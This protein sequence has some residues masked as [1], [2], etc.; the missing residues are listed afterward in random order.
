MSNAAQEPRRWT[1][2]RHGATQRNVTLDRDPLMAVHEVIEVVDA[3]AYDALL[4]ERDALKAECREAKD[5][6]A[7]V[8][9]IDWSAGNPIDVSF[10][11]EGVKLFAASMCDWFRE[12]GGENYVSARCVDPRDGVG[13]EITMRR[14]DGKLP[15]EVVAELRAELAALKEKAERGRVALSN[16]VARFGI[17]QPHMGGAYR[18]GGFVPGTNAGRTMEQDD[19]EARICAS[20][21]F[22]TTS[23]TESPL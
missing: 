8:N 18:W 5:A 17:A 10:K 11:G 9:S 22:L 21:D 3:S 4:A 6:F 2:Y 19:T 23:A 12:N 15:A 1:L 7:R 16:L 14:L 20:P 13:Y